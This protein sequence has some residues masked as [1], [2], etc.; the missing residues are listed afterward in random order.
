MTD[1]DEFERM[2]VRVGESVRW[3]RDLHGRLC[4][5]VGLVT[6]V[7][8][9]RDAL[10][11]VEKTDVGEQLATAKLKVVVAALARLRDVA[12]VD[13]RGQ[14]DRALRALEWL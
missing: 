9:G 4:V 7:F 13:Q 3:T 11:G 12:P 5:V 6:Y 10:A 8:D 1:A 2:L 14:Y